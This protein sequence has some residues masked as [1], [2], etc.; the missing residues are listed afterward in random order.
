MTYRDG[1]I[2]SLHIHTQYLIVRE[3]I[4]K[5]MEEQNMAKKKSVKRK[6]VKRKAKAKGNPRLGKAQKACKGKT[7]NGYKA[8]VKRE[9]KKK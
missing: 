8:C 9:A 2:L 3:I 4:T 7:G 6:P 5:V 1:L